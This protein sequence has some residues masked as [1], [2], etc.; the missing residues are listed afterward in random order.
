V[1]AV[2]LDRNG[3]EFDLGVKPDQEVPA[4]AGGSSDDPVLGAASDWL[5]KGAWE[6]G[7]GPREAV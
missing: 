5:S 3:T 1:V 4:A 7:I 2:D 6:I